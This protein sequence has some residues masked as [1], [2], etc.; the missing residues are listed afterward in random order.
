MKKGYIAISIA[1]AMAV[2]MAATSSL[3]VAHNHAK[4]KAQNEKQAKTAVMFRKSLLQLV[5]SNMGPLGAMAKG[6]IPMD[7]AVIEVN[8]ERIEFLA[9]MMH[10]YFA[11]DT[12]AYSVETDAKNELWKNHED[13]G[14]KIDDMVTAAAQLNALAKAGKSDDFRSGI[15]ALG[16]TCK[17]CHDDYKTD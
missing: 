3:A 6:N 4:P 17:A 16:G 2:S 11:L 5:R 1:G 12:T 10:D 15:G 8:S 9:G 13:F 7:G 14:Q